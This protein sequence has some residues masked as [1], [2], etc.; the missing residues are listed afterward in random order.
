MR[1]ERLKV[2]RARLNEIWYDGI[3]PAGGDIRPQDL[4]E[5]EVLLQEEEAILCCDMVLPLSLQDG[6]GQ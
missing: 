6:E 4:A 5:F 3:G 1:E 2:V